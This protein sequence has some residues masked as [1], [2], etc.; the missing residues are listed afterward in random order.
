M[1]STS[2]GAALRAISSSP[3][4]SIPAFLVPAFPSSARA[5]SATTSTQSQIGRAP[6]SIPPEVNF[7]VTYPTAPK[8][9]RPSPE[10]LRPTVKVEGPLGSLS[11][12]IPP[13]VHIEHDTVTKKAFV[14]VEDREVRKQ[15]EMWGT[16][17]A[18][19]Q[20]HILGVSEGHNAILRL[21]G[22]GYRA[23][24]ED[25][26]TTKEPEYDGQK[27]VVLK[28][29]YSH[30]IE[31]PVPKGMTASTPQPTRILLEG[32]EKEV[33]LQFAAEI[34]QWRKPEPYK[35]KGIFVNGETI[36]LKAK[37]IK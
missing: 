26:A 16:T 34:R 3:S 18:Y 5:F 35:G 11:M 32:P 2:R 1:L 9:A 13:F 20:N 29:G 12:T 24:V 21:I 31:L 27:F 36:K 28:V 22:V 30:P 15:R 4:I 25:T 14:T 8:N 17:R 6:L 7:T 19:L 10:Q 33:V 37:K 23:S